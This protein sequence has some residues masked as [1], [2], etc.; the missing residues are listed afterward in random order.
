MTHTVVEDIEP[1][2]NGYQHGNIKNNIPV[3]SCKCSNNKYLVAIVSFKF[4]G[5]FMI[6]IKKLQNCRK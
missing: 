5:K 1:P 6:V 3:Y 4:C 2:D